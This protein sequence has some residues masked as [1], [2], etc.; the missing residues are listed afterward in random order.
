MWGYVQNVIYA[1]SQ[2]REESQCIRVGVWRVLVVWQICSTSNLRLYFR[3]SWLRNCIICDT[4]LER[5][6]GIHTA[7]E[8]KTRPRREFLDYMVKKLILF[9]VACYVRAA[10]LVAHIGITELSFLNWI[11]GLQYTSVRSMF[12]PARFIRVR[13]KFAVFITAVNYLA[14]VSFPEYLYIHY[15]TSDEPCNMNSS[16]KN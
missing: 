11:T 3:S 1:S 10:T 9:I 13:V 8:F 12:T 2:K 6:Q 4:Q 16:A 14:L 15:G 5:C 7:G